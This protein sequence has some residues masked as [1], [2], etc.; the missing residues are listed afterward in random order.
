MMLDIEITQN[1]PNTIKP[2]QMTLPK[3][4]HAHEFL[5]VSASLELYWQSLTFPNMQPLNQQEIEIHEIWNVANS[6][7]QPILLVSRGDV[8]TGEIAYSPNSY[9]HTDNTNDTSDLCNAKCCND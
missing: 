4:T 9:R 3:N 1:A 5:F 7:A 8:C 2:N 6:S